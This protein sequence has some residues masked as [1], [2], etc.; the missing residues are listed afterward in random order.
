MN[1]AD[2]TID[3]A[4]IAT[5]AC[6]RLVLLNYQISIN[7]DEP[8][9]LYTDMKDET[10]YDMFNNLIIYLHDQKVADFSVLIP[11]IDKNIIDKYYK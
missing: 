3:K 5:Y 1:S 7:S 6:L 8:V 2:N 11:F 4:K 10:D 9:K